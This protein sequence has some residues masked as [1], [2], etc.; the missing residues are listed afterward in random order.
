MPG[1]RRGP[2]QPPG[3]FVIARDLAPGPHPLLTAF[4]GLDKLPSFERL[5]SELK[6]KEDLAQATQVHIVDSDVWMYV[7]PHKLP[8]MARRRRGWSPVVTPEDCV[9]IGKEHLG[10]SPPIIVYLDIL[11]E[12]CHVVQ[13][14][15]GQ[16]LWD[17][18][19]DYVDRP[20]EIEAYRFAVEE[21]RRLGANDA[22]LADYLQVEWV[23]EKDH[24]RLLKTLGVRRA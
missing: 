8:E 7:A 20:T 16:E 11:H 18:A 13:R 21:A 3:E 5:R 6:A 12:L 17:T 14:Q 22:F 2:P 19:Y 23:A 15:H 10:D 4:P 9:V 24:H 1:S